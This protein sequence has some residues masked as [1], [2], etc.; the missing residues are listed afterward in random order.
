MD[1][2]LLELE[3][4]IFCFKVPVSLEDL[5]NFNFERSVEDGYVRV[6]L[7]GKSELNHVIECTNENEY[8]SAASL[9]SV[10]KAVGQIILK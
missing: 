5:P 9:P 7:E 10:L 3:T 4:N 8:L 2:L 6:K 1:F